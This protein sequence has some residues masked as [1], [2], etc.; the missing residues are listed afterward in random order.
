MDIKTRRNCLRISRFREQS[1]RSLVNILSC[2][3][4]YSGFDS[5][6]PGPDPDLFDD[7]HDS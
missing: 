7:I 5:L 6:L 1:I 3:P 2:S 4:D